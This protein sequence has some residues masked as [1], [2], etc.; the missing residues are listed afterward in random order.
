MPAAVLGSLAA[1]GLC[2]AASPYLAKLTLSVPDRD[3]RRWWIGRP[4]G[5][6]RV[7]VTGVTGVVLG[8][9]AGAAAGW[10][11]LL[12]AFF[13]LALLGTPLSVIDFEWHRLPDRLVR[14]AAV[15]GLAL[16]AVAAAVRQ[17]R[18]PYLRAIEGAAAVFAVLFLIFFASPRAFGLGDVK[19]ATVLGGY[20]GWHSW[21]AVFYGIFAGFLLGTVVALVLVATRRA[22]LKTALAFG[23]MLLLGALLVLAFDLT[24]SLV[25]TP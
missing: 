19:L 24:P 11:A 22:S 21:L 12:P 5:R 4:A 13:A 14:L 6:A 18:D 3:E 2:V 20:L 16:L 9:L 17:D 25:S 23:P 1:A 7:L 10:S 15:G 8:G